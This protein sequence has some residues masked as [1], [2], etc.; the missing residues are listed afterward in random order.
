[1]IFN[2]KLMLKGEI[3]SFGSYF[4]SKIALNRPI[5]HPWTVF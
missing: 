5:S 4:S 3:P 2:E 1:M